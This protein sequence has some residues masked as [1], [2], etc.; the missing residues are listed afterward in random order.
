MN[1]SSVRASVNAMSKKC[2]L[3]F[4]AV[5]LL[6]VLSGAVTLPSVRAQSVAGQPDEMKS[7]LKVVVL[8][9]GPSDKKAPKHRF[10]SKY[11]P[12]DLA[13]EVRDDED[14]PLPGATVEFKFPPKEG[15]TALPANKDAKVLTTDA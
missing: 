1:N 13:V 2:C 15:P 14:R 4:R 6:V 9:S 11:S 7:Q 3:D 5:G 12:D 10:N 8:G